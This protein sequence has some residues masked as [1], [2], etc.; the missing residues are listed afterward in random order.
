MVIT[1]KQNTVEI[2][3]T[4]RSM[5]VF[6]GKIWDQG[7]NSIFGNVRRQVLTLRYWQRPIHIFK[8]RFPVWTMPLTLLTNEN[9][10]LRERPSMKVS[11]VKS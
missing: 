3:L 8:K 10:G 11:D 7:F 4:T 6:E 2:R 1:T 9:A 5:A